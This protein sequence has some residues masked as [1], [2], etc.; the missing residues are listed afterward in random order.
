MFRAAVASRMEKKSNQLAPTC[1]A[2]I[3]MMT[4]S[5]TVKMS[6]S[7]LLIRFIT[8]NTRPVIRSCAISGGVSDRDEFG[9]EV[10][11]WVKISVRFRFRIQAKRVLV[12]K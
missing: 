3:L 7:N 5:P 11:D 10:R 12:A 8:P 2:N 4:S 6:L 1:R 9:G